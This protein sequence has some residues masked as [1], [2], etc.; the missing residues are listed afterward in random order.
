MAGYR[1]LLLVCV[2][3]FVVLPLPASA[4]GAGNIASI[5]SIEGHNWRHGDIEDVLKTVAFLRGRSTVDIK[6]PRTDSSSRT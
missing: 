2:V 4:F 3:L 6:S 5:S 1:T